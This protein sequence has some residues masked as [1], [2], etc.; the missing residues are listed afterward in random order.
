[1]VIIVVKTAVGA[2]LGFDLK[3]NAFQIVAEGSPFNTARFN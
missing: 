2:G 1:M 3:D